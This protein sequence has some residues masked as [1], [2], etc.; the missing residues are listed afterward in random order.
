M[1]KDLDLWDDYHAYVAPEHRFDSVSGIL[2][3][4][5]N[6]KN[7]VDWDYY[8][9]LTTTTGDF[10]IHT[11]LLRDDPDT[12]TVKWYSIPTQCY[13]LWESSDLVNWSVAEDWQTGTGLF[14]YEFRSILEFERMFYL[15][16]C[17]RTP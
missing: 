9:L 4:Y 2:E 3:Q 12:V 15:L 14:I 5:T 16:E 17:E 13:R 6:Y 11:T 7:G 1:N 10:R 8:Q